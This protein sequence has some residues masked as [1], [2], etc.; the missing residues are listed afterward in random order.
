MTERTTMTD[1]AQS[2]RRAVIDPRSLV[3]IGAV[4]TMVLMLFGA[5]VW[6]DGQF[7]ELRS[8]VS[9]LKYELRTIRE[10]GSYRWTGSDM[11]IWAER[12]ARGNPNLVVPAAE[13]R[14]TNS[15]KR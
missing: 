12:L 8:S 4:G 9:E 14:A 11:A 10:A 1:E 6:L 2:S 5:K 15:E 3:P 13:H 7:A